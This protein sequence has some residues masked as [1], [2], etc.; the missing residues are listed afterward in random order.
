M[1]ELDELYLKCPFFGSRKVAGINRKRA[2]RRMRILGIE[3][4][5]PKPNLSEVTCCA[6]SQSKDQTTSGAPILPTSRCVVAFS[7]WSP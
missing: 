4:Y 1:R 3:A 2:Q 5:Y 7:T 6:A